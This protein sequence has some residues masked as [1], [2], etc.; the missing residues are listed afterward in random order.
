[1]LRIGMVDFDSSH[2]VNFTKI[3][4]HKVDDEEQWIDG[5]RVVLG[6]ALPSQVMDEEGVREYR[7]ACEKMGVEMVE[8][9]EDML[10]EIDAVML[11]SNDGRTH[12]KRARPFLEAGIPTFVDK[13]LSFSLEEARRMAALSAENS[14]PLFSASSLRYAPEVVEVCTNS[15]VYG[16]VMGALTYS[17]AKDQQDNPGLLYYGIHA[18]EPLYALMGAGCESVSC[19]SAPDAEVITARWSDGRVATL[20]GLKTGSH[21]FGFCAWCENEIT[22]GPVST[23]FIYRELLKRVLKMFETGEPPLDIEETIEIITFG[24]AAVESKERG[25]EQVRLSELK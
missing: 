15:D 4:N 22:G 16:E 3:L 9:P 18:I 1:M 2:A 19:S 21:G 24:L 6:C 23:R 8:S 10:G 14:A 17:P 7:E 11:E 13:P 25:G 5:G 20:R 12:L